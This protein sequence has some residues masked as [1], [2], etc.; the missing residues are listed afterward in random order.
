MEE[1]LKKKILKKKFIT[2]KIQSHSNFLKENYVEKLRK[3][4]LA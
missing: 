3:K 2:W 4:T 1:R